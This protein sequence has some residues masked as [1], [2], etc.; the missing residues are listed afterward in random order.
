MAF[1]LDK[2]KALM[3]AAMEVPPDTKL[4]K[5][6]AVKVSK[7]KNVTGMDKEVV[8]EETKSDFVE[9]RHLVEY[10]LT[11]HPKI[12]YEQTATIV[13]KHFPGKNYDAGAFTWFKL[14]L[15]KTGKAKYHETIS[16]Q[17]EPTTEIA[18]GE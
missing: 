16:A 7:A 9:V 4:K 12:R 15:L 8:E 3:Q 5:E 6:I 1:D 11:K 13:K 2:A 10:L 17:I 18:K 14:E